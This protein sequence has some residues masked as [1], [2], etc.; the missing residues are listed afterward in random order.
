[1]LRVDRTSNPTDR[2]SFTGETVQAEAL[3]PEAMAHVV[4]AEIT[5]Q[6]DH[7]VLTETI[8]R[9]GRIRFDEPGRDRSADQPT[10]R[11]GRRSVSFCDQL[12]R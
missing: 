11:L 7:D 3:P 6:I 8:M 5:S 12:A 2:R 10:S 9:E 1:M 4:R